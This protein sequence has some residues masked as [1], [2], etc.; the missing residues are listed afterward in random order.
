MSRAIPLLPLYAFMVWTGT[1]LPSW[2]VTFEP[3]EHQEHEFIVH[4]CKMCIL[5]RLTWNSIITVQ[6]L[7]SQ[8]LHSTKIPQLEHLHFT[9][10]KFHNSLL[11][12]NGQQ[13]SYSLSIFSQYYFHFIR[14]LWNNWLQMLRN[15]VHHSIFIWQEHGAH[16]TL[17]TR[18]FS[19]RMSNCYIE[20]WFLGIHHYV[21]TTKRIPLKFFWSISHKMWKIILQDHKNKA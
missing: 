15:N 2:G 10:S 1:T 6:S 3:T 19:T 13:L 4:L 9:W 8:F 5:E 18:F 21:Q 11:V 16:S 14:T 20:I 12:I 7:S 17:K